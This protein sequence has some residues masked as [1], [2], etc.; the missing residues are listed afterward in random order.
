MRLRVV[1]INRYVIT[2]STVSYLTLDSTRSFPEVQIQG[3]ECTMSTDIFNKIAF[4]YIKTGTDQELI[5]QLKDFL[6][7]YNNIFA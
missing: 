3:D 5:S 4:K 2:I 1:Y 7:V 6:K